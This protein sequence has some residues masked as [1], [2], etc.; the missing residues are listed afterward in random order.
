MF[1]CSYTMRNEIQQYEEV[2]RGASHTYKAL[3]GDEEGH[4][5]KSNKE[6]VCRCSAVI[7]HPGISARHSKKQNTGHQQRR[8]GHQDKDDISVLTS[9]TLCRHLGACTHL[10][11]CIWACLCM[12]RYTETKK[13]MSCF[14]IWLLNETRRQCVFEFACAPVFMR[15]RATV[16]RARR[17]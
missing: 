11:K 15:P 7:T 10:L 16:C 17:W 9:H 13:I 14:L 2:N 6:A 12:H 1:V 4:C 5:Q 8:K 3:S